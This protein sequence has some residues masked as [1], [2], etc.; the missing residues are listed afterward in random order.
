MGNTNILARRQLIFDYLEMP[1]EGKLPLKQFLRN[2]KMQRASFHRYEGEWRAKKKAETEEVIE[3]RKQIMKGKVMDA[4]AR[5]EGR[6]PP[7][8]NKVGIELS[9]INDG[10]KVALARKVYN[11]AMRVGATASEKDLAVR[12]LGML[13]D[14][15]EEKVIIERSAEEY[16]RGYIEEKRWL[17]EQ[18]FLE[19]ERVEEVQSESALLPDE[20][21]KDT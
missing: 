9:E 1:E 17:R 12:M 15:K 2:H 20:I 3:E 10:E 19:S 8:R 4:W 13:I 18:G 16:A 21:R 6:E 7:K 14:K 11:D 5:V